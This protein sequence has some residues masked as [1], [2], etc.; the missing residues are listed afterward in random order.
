ML[1][2]VECMYAYG[3][4]MMGKN[5]NDNN[6]S[7]IHDG[8]CQTNHL[9]IGNDD[10]TGILDIL[11]SS[12]YWC[13]YVWKVVYKCNKLNICTEFWI[14]FWKMEENEWKKC[15]FISSQFA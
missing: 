3:T 15:T 7:S 1:N 5:M 13:S 8:W 11:I 9:G 12:D 6:D 10:A 14:Q 2:N 4:D